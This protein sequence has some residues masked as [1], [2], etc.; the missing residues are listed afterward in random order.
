MQ[1]FIDSLA[2][3]LEAAEPLSEE[4][5]LAKYEWDSLAIISIVSLIDKTFSFVPDVQKLEACKT[6]GDV[7]KLVSDRQC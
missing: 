6:V 2:D 7:I 5:E 4:S 1:D 3:I